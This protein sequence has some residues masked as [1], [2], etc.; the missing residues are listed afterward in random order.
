MSA[1]HR[2]LFDDE[3][4]ENDEEGDEEEELDPSDPKSRRSTHER[5]QAKL[6]EDIRKLEA[7]N[8]AKRQWQ[9]S[10]EARANDRPLNSLLEVGDL[11][12]D[13]GA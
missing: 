7:A 12:S 4:D 11:P 13:A 6:R 8:V 1:V 2:D 3:D 10:G 5:R 9:L